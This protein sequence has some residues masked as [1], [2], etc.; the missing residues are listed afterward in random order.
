M[1][2]KA[3]VDFKVMML[4]VIAFLSVSAFFSSYIIEYKASLHTRL[5]PDNLSN[6]YVHQTRR[7]DSSRRKSMLPPTKPVLPQAVV[8]VTPKPFERFLVPIIIR[9]QLTKAT[10]AFRELMYIAIHTQRTLVLPK[11]G[12]SGIGLRYALR[13]P[14][15]WCTW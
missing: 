5:D 9:E 6:E 2:S 4:G 12:V 1:R 15:V 3:I 11:V 7:E 8:T 13:F 10:M 14:R